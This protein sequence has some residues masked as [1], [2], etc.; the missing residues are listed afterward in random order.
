[1]TRSGKENKQRGVLLRK[2]SKVHKKMCQESVRERKGGNVRV[3]TGFGIC[4]QACVTCCL[5]NRARKSFYSSAF[6]HWASSAC[7]QA[8][9]LALVETSGVLVAPGRGKAAWAS[10]RA[11]SCWGNTC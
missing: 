7:N 9:R 8:G 4:L 1:M 2:P 10:T 11:L 5:T 3:E 6:F